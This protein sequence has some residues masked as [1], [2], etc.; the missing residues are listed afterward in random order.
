MLGLRVLAVCGGV[1]LAGA[2]TTY[3]LTPAYTAESLEGL[4]RQLGLLEAKQRAVNRGAYNTNDDDD[5]DN[6]QLIVHAFDG[7]SQPASSAG[8]AIAQSP[9]QTTPTLTIRPTS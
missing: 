2:V 7:A 5:D 6:E 3:F 4:Q 9:P 8:P 1:A